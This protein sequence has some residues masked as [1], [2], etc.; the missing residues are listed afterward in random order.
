MKTWKDIRSYEPSFST[1]RRQA[2]VWGR[3]NKTD[4]QQWKWNRWPIRGQTNIPKLHRW[5][6]QLTMK[7]ILFQSWIITRLIMK[8]KLIKNQIQIHICSCCYFS[9]FI[10]F[11][12][13]FVNPSDF[14]H[15]FILPNNFYDPIS[16]IITSLNCVCKKKVK[17][18][19]P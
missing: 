2:E 10:N 17:S 18:L 8:E 6:S 13:S 19:F 5:K 3:W 7:I 15:V 9:I 11:F 1:K 12:R 4:G 16:S 14:S